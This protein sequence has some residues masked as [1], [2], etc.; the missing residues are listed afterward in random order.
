MNSNIQL[1]EMLLL[2]TIKS[3]PYNAQGY[4]LIAAA[5]RDPINAAI[6]F[7]AIRAGVTLS[8]AQIAALITAAGKD[9]S[10]PLYQNGYYFQVLDASPTVRQAR[11]TPPINFWYC[12][13]QSVQKLTI[14]SI[15]LL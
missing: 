7:G 9:I 6:N 3:I 10:V 4:G 12:D 15:A 13:G 1:A 14:N 11:A 8:Q 2:T 5:A